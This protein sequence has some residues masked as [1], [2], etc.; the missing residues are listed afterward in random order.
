MVSGFRTRPNPPIPRTGFRDL[1]KVRI[2]FR[3]D[4]AFRRKAAGFAVVPLPAGPNLGGMGYGGANPDHAN[5]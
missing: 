2:F 1:V 5:P 4:Q 3:N